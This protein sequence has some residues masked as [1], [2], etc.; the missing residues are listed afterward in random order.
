[1]SAIAH[2]RVWDALDMMGI[3]EIPDVVKV[4]IE[5]K[6]VTVTRHRD[7]PPRLVDGEIP[8]VD[9]VFAIVASDPE[10][11]TKF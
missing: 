6:T 10:P 11:A 3:E 5:P 4:T 9:E 1:M 2:A 8:T 7:N